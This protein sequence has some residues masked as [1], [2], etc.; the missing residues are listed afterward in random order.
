METLWYI[1]KE[2][3]LQMETLWH[4]P[5]NTAKLKISHKNRLSNYMVNVSFVHCPVHNIFTGKLPG[6]SQLYQISTLYLDAV[7]YYC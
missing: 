6:T 3:S 7:I 5:L 2:L 4:I 1:P